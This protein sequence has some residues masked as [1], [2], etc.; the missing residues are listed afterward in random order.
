VAVRVQSMFA[1]RTIHR[2][3]LVFIVAGT[4]MLCA[5]AIVGSP[6]VGF[7]TCA[8]LL[9][10]SLYFFVSAMKWSGLGVDAGTSLE[11]RVTASGK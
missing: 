5:Y 11:G 9:A 10:G 3:D 4:V 6:L 1:I 2:H 7:A 8:V